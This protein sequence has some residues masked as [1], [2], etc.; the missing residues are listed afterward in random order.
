M[1]SSNYK[2]K[3]VRSKKNR[4]KKKCKKQNKYY[5]PYIALGFPVFFYAIVL[6]NEIAELDYDL[7]SL[8]EDY[9]ILISNKCMFTKHYIGLN[10]YLIIKFYILSIIHCTFVYTPLYFI[11]IILVKLFTNIVYTP[12]NQFSL[13]NNTDYLLYNLEKIYWSDLKINFIGSITLNEFKPK[14]DIHIFLL[15]RIYLENA[16]RVRYNDYICNS[17]YTYKMYNIFRISDKIYHY[18]HSFKKNYRLSLIYKNFVVTD[19]KGIIMYTKILLTHILCMCQ[20]NSSFSRANILNIIGY[21]Y[22][23]FYDIQDS[24]ALFVYSYSKLKGHRKRI[25]KF[26]IADYSELL[27]ILKQNIDCLQP[28]GIAKFKYHIKAFFI[29]ILFC[30]SIMSYKLIMLLNNWIV[31]NRVFTNKNM[32]SVNILNFKFLIL[33]KTMFSFDITGFKYYFRHTYILSNKIF[34]FHN[35]C[36]RK[37]IKII[38]DYFS[39]SL[40]YILSPDRLYFSTVDFDLYNSNYDSF[41]HIFQAFI[42]MLEIVLLKTILSIMFIL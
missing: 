33:S 31:H 16:R 13:H 4:Y 15:L 36:Y 19:C 39:C 40:W 35:L 42:T 22:S 30:N 27:E 26:S 2:I 24:C 9:F 17:R 25:N 32:L 29:P 1:R 3:R 5:E 12:F 6:A 18:F 11:N 23:F 10:K 21:K 38:S 34:W 14:I 8:I 28:E 37:S 20:I 41:I 7:C